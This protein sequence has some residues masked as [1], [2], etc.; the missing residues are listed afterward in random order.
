MIHIN[1][2]ELCDSPLVMGILVR[3]TLEG[4]LLVCILD[5]IPACRFVELKDIVERSAGSVCHA[6][7]EQGATTSVVDGD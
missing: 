5:V 1:L 6:A 4:H 2:L 3:M 7:V